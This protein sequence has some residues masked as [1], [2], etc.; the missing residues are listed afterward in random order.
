MTVSIVGSAGK[1]AQRRFK[2]L[3]ER[4]GARIVDVRLHDTPLLSGLAN[5]DNLA[6][7]THQIR[8]SR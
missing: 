1:S 4:G 6:W 7:F 3:R 8:P 5:K 2:L